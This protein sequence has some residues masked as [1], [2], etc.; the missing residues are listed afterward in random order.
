MASTRGRDIESSSVRWHDRQPRLTISQTRFMR[1]CTGGPATATT[2]DELS[3][4]KLV[5]HR[6]KTWETVY[7]NVLHANFQSTSPFEDRMLLA[8]AAILEIYRL[9]KGISINRALKQLVE[10]KVI[11]DST[12]NGHTDTLEQWVLAA[13][14][15]ATL[16]LHPSDTHEIGHFDIET[17]G[18]KSFSQ[19]SIS[20]SLASRPLYE[21]LRGFG[22]VLP[23]SPG[24]NSQ[25]KSQSDD[26]VDPLSARPK[27]FQVSYLNAATL[28]YLAGI[29]IVW[30]DCIGSHLSF[31][32]AVPALSLFKVPSF[33]NLHKATSPN[34]EM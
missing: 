34:L 17:S 12:K 21:L 9:R 7:E 29:K 15:A 16:L 5:Q 22:E 8:I 1:A 13:I 10:D 25:F 33:C 2:E 6:T 24:I 23:K 3:Y 32:P 19:R 30:V 11:R 26:Q 28:H 27:S 4:L 14:G 31:D 20:K 18:A